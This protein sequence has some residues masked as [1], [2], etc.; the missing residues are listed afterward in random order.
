M[1]ILEET[2]SLK[3]DFDRISNNKSRNHIKQKR[4]N[5]M[6]RPA[7]IFFDIDGTLLDFGKK[8]Q[9]A[10]V[11]ASPQADLLLQC[12]SLRV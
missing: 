12:Q 7:I 8:D 11:S 5:Y 4:G 6:N 10:S 2:R 3:E 1:L 9:T